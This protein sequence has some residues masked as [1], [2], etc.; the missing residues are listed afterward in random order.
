MAG[1]LELDEAPATMPAP[2]GWLTESVPTLRA[3]FAPAQGLATWARAA[4]IEGSIE[5][6][7][8]HNDDHRHLKRATIGAVWTNGEN[9]RGGNLIAGE[10]DMPQ[11]PKGW[12]DAFVH[13]QLRQWFG[14]VPRF[15]I[16]LYAPYVAELLE[17]EDF[18]ALFALIE[19]ELYHCGQA[20]DEF[21]A[22][23]FT[24][25]GL[26]KLAMRAH[27][28]E[29]FVG[30]VARYGFRAG[31]GQTRALVEV[32]AQAPRFDHETL[33]RACCGCGASL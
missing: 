13:Y 6:G 28:V 16:T 33:R 14:I 30:V 23:K 24:K 17:D 29:E 1:F 20:R 22:P 19:H 27:D 18:P 9:R 7:R 12:G 3:S 32:A 15:R 4:F 10:A 31:A 8:L 26:P 11:P 25:D 5:G 2:P 21:G